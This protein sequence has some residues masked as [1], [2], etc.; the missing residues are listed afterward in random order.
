MKIDKMSAATKLIFVCLLCVYG[1]FADR[2]VTTDIHHECL[3]NTSVCGSLAHVTAVGSE[4]VLHYVVTSIGLP[5]V[6]VAYTAPE[7]K[8]SVDWAGLLSNNYTEKQ[9]S[10]HLEPADGVHYT[11]TLLFTKLIDYNDTDDK[12][13]MT[14]YSSSPDKW[15]IYDLST[16]TW[17]NLTEVSHAKDNKVMLKASSHNPVELWQYNGSFSIELSAYSSSGRESQLP[18]LQYSENITQFDMNIDHVW[19]NFTKSRFAVELVMVGGGKEEMKTDETR[20]IDDEYTPGVFTIFNWLSDAS[21]DNTGFLQWKPVCYQSKTRSRSEATGMKHYDLKELDSMNKELLKDT[22]AFG[23]YGDSL[24]SQMSRASNL[25]FGLS[26]DGGYNKTQVLTWSGSLGY[27]VPPAD[28]VSTL[29]III[30]SAGLGIPVVIIIFGGIFICIKKKNAKP[31]RPLGNIQ[32]NGY[33]QIS[34]N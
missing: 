23:Y 29:V 5:T 6:F 31:D 11:Y 3:R 32:N 10:V 28:T 13:D 19:T 21:A 26:K 14:K 30:I 7:V 33:Q 12:A 25:S 15:T 16:F 24:M 8:L 20:S 27:G 4:D 34:N 9:H 17:D 1:V 2:K 22:V 18:H